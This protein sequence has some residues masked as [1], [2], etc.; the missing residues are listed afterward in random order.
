[1]LRV[2]VLR[3]MG[4]VV[5]FEGRERRGGRKEE[6]GEGGSKTRRCHTRGR[7]EE[8]ETKKG[9]E[10]IEETCAYMMV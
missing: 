8:N 10:Y 5:L 3:M 7:R 9:D 6:E 2:V 4:M 1:L